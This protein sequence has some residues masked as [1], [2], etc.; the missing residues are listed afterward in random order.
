VPF[1]KSQKSKPKET[2]QM[3]KFSELNISQMKADLDKKDAE[4]IAEMKAIRIA[5][6]AKLAASK[7][8]LDSMLTELRQF[9]RETKKPR[10]DAKTKPRWDALFEHV[11]ESQKFCIEQGDAMTPSELR[12]HINCVNRQFSFDLDSYWQEIAAKCVE[13]CAGVKIKIGSENTA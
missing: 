1:F 5:T 9:D 4:F 7:I 13:A 2:D 12:H 10:L 11:L 3:P 8:Q 6:N